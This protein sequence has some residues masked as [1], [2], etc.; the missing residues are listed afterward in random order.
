MHLLPHGAEALEQVCRAHGP[1]LTAV[2]EAMRQAPIRHAEGARAVPVPLPPLAPTAQELASQRRA[3]RLAADEPVG[4]LPRQGWSGEA[5]A[6]QLGLGRTTVC[7]DR[8]APTCPDRQG[9]ADRGQR[10]LNPAKADVVQRWK[11]GCRDAR[12]LWAALRP[13]GSRGS[14]PPVARET[15]RRRQAQG[16]APR[17]RLIGKPLVAVSAPRPPALTARRA[18]WLV[19][20]RADQRPAVASQ[21]LPQVRAQPG[22]LA[23]ASSLTEDLV[24]LIRQRQGAPRDP[25]VERAAQSTLGVFQRFAPGLRDDEAAVTAGMTRPWST[26]PVA[27]PRNRLKMLTR[28]MCGRARLDLLGRRFLLAPRRAPRP[29]PRPQA[30]AEAQPATA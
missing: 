29:T 2:Q 16:V 5:I 27:G 22:A 25:G 19:G 18:A 6:R 21:P 9:R 17:Q 30:P 24:Q 11:A 15:P 20:R 14:D 10:V 12:Q 28:Q 13:R 4:A 7:R 26:G 1:V 3:P 8:H 23:D